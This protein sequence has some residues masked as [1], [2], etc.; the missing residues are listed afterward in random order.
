MS[1]GLGRHEHFD[2]RN[3]DYLISEVLTPDLADIKKAVLSVRSKSMM[4]N[5]DPPLHRYF[6][7]SSWHGDQGMSPSCTAFALSH[8]MVDGPVTHP[9]ENPIADPLTIYREIQV[10]DR[11]EG[12]FYSEGATSLAMAKAAMRRKWIGEYRWGYSLAEFIAAIK[13]SPVL[14]GVNWYS[15]CDSPG[16]KDAIIR[17]KGFIRG[18][19]EIE[20][21]GAD[22]SH[23]LARLKQSWGRSWG[24]HGHAMLPF[25]DLERLI[26]EDGDVLLFR[27]L[28]TD[29]PRTKKN[30]AT[31]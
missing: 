3:L 12:R 11:E 2:P 15:G 10:V 17:V 30:E 8:A 21:N 19:H 25:E 13:I 31:I 28:K 6:Y 9:G 4:L 16:G 24:N 5:L 18:G 7:D 27:E 29:D 14:L 22:F 26:N 23:G 1:K 20:C